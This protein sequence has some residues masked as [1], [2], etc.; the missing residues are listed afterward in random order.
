MDSST[1]TPDLMEN[2]AT[3]VENSAGPIGSAHD[4]FVLLVTD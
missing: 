3:E 1:Y 2:A 4:F